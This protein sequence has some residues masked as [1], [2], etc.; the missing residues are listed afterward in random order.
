M[1]S[2]VFLE[3]SQRTASMFLLVVPLNVNVQALYPILLIISYKVR[4]Y[5]HPH[6]RESGTRVGFI[7]ML[8]TRQSL[9]LRKSFKSITCAWL[10]ISILQRSSN[11]PDFLLII[12]NQA[13][14]YVQQHSCCAK[15]FSFNWFPKPQKPLDIVVCKLLRFCKL[16]YFTAPQ[17]FAASRSK[18]LSCAEMS[19]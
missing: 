18:A 7:V 2:Q 6:Y 5:L 13:T 17:L 19:L 16:S 4:L 3:F 14:A 15:R 12:T 10:L 11:S 8:L 1:I 9:N